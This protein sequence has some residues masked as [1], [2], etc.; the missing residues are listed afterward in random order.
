MS[1]KVDTRQVSKIADEVKD[2]RHDEQGEKEHILL[3]CDNMTGE[4]LERSRFER[5][6][7]RKEKQHLGR[8]R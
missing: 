3:P 1:T 6:E 5:Q 8:K 7:N 2:L 4:Q